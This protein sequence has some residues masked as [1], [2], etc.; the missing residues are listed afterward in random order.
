MIARRL[1]SARRFGLLFGFV[2]G[3]LSGLPAQAGTPEDRDPAEWPF[4]P[5]S[6]WNT[7]LGS[8][9]AVDAASA[10]CS[11]ALQDEKLAADINAAQWSHPIFLAAPTDPPVPIVVKGKTVATVRVPSAAEPAQPRSPDS[12]AHLHIIDPER[13]YVHELWHASRRK[14][15][16]LRAESYTRNELHG[17]GVGQG[18]ER[19]YGGSAIGGLI[20]RRELSQGIR[21]ALALALP[22]SHLRL[23]PVWPATLE[24]NGAH[25][26]YRGAVPMGQLVTLVPKT[27]LDGLGLS[28]E[29]KVIARALAEYGAYVVDASADLTFY[30]EPS[31]EPDLT[32]ARADLAKLR[33]LLRCVQNAGKAAVGG[34][35]T[36]TAPHAPALRPPLPEPAALVKPSLSKSK[37]AATGPQ[38]KARR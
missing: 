5:D 1:A 24:D 17:L 16:S 2:L 30:A 8:A 6:P 14:D 13:R 7:P 4:A 27:D 21:H 15:G 10:P 9:V 36:R 20:R 29:G 18:G 25:A 32:G 11:R 19:A 31:A 23:G 34:P 38:G 37:P 26:T 28:A 12:D 3:T 22:R 33:P 35:G